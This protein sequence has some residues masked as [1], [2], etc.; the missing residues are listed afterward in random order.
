MTRPRLTRLELATVTAARAGL[1]FVERAPEAAV[2]ELVEIE[3]AAGGMRTGIV[4]DV[5]ERRAAVQVLA[6]S[7]G[8]ALTGTRVRLSGEPFRLGVGEDLLGRV[9]DG[10]GRPLDGGPPPRALAWEDVSGRPINPAARESP[11][12]PVETGVSVVDVLH[13]LARGQ[14]LPVFGGYGLPGDDLAIRI[15]RKSVV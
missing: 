7:Q 15:D 9:L 5:D 1:I 10:M 6:G 2:G 12:H 11:A 3:D 8:L 13:T 4:L 14:K